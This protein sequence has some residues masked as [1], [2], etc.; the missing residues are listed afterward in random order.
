MSRRVR[1]N[2]CDYLFWGQHRLN[3]RKGEGGNVAYMLL[4]LDGELDPNWLQRAIAAVMRTHP[5]T[6][7]WF[8]STLLLGR[9]HWRFPSDP[10]DADT[11]SRRALFF[12]DFRNQS[13]AADLLKARSAVGNVAEWDTRNGPLVRLELYV[14]PDQR[15]RL[16]LRWPHAL[17]D[18]EGAQWFLNELTRCEA[19]AAS[20]G[21]DEFSI[22]SPLEWPA[23]LAA[24]AAAVD[25]LDH[26]G[27][28]AK[29]GLFKKGIA[30]QGSHSK[31]R[32]HLLPAESKTGP[33]DHQA[34]HRNWSAEET[35]RVQQ[36]AKVHTPPGP[37]LYARNLAACVVRAIHRLYTDRG[38]ATDAYLITLPTRVGLGDDA[39]RMFER[40]PMI[41]NY[42]V[43]PML[44]I[45]HD[46]AE[47]RRAVGE[48]ILAQLAE[49]QALR[50]DLLQ[51]S[52]MWAASLIHAW[53][54]ELIF[55]LPLGS[56]R[57]A[58]GFSFYGE[59]DPPV[60]QIGPAR[61][62][63]LWGG[64]PNTNPPALNPVFSRFDERL[65]FSLT[66]T[67]PAVSDV[68]AGAYV[69]L[70]E[71]EMFDQTPTKL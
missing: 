5:A 48:V 58:S 44:C 12:E 36:V 45:P 61:V 4:D 40:R 67:R 25:P 35:A 69:H 23:G 31:H 27:F 49:Y 54:Y 56:G 38:I 32:I 6:M 37:A 53:V 65:N 22:T 21:S 71:S 1:L 50:G 14:L 20:R 62:L 70:I 11:A 24:D 41:G 19:T 60:R 18:A 29:W 7:G 16:I 55:L 13:N 57:F 26:V 33:I 46:A 51:W 10:A 66:Y 64:G 39:R 3:A 30:Y 52:M 43:S 59:T 17:M 2:P 28:L 9:P 63:N 42:L 34:I 8:G 68:T 15:S 47:D